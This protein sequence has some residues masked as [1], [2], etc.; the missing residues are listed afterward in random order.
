MRSQ[1]SYMYTFYE[2]V[3]SADY[4][5][6]SIQFS[7]MFYS[8]YYPYIVTN[9]E[10]QAANEFYNGLVNGQYYNKL[11][12]LS[13]LQAF[14]ENIIEFVIKGTDYT[15]LMYIPSYYLLTWF[16]GY[17]ANSID[18]LRSPYN[19]TFTNADVNIEFNPR[20][21]YSLPRAI[22]F[23]NTVSLVYYINNNKVVTTVGND[24]LV[25]NPHPGL[26]QAYC[27]YLL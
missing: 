7:K 20:F 10:D 14:T 15:T 25:V 1:Y 23:L 18:D 19:T 2:N 3:S 12:Y 21:W 17:I 8:I 27:N 6:K 26:I 16:R 4:E 9:K 22:L 11:T 24:T 5:T 13:G